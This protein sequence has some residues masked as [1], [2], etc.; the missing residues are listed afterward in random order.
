[1]FVVIALV[2]DRRRIDSGSSATFATP[3]V[4]HFCATLLIAAFVTTPRQ[5]AATLSGCLL[6]LGGAGLVYSILVARGA[7]RQTAYVPVLED[8]IWH[9]G[10]PLLAYASLLIA[11]VVMHREPEGALYCVGAC[12]LLLL[13]VGIHNA[14]DTAIWTLLT[15]QPPRGRQDEGSEGSLGAQPSGGSP[16]STT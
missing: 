5:S 15:S 6:A 7:R 12:A 9:V 10:L 8:W 3:T 1:M 11:A 14:W 13:F 16:S 2:A 4:V